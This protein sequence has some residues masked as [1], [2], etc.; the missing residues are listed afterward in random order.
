MKKTILAILLAIIFVFT[1]CNDAD[2]NSVTPAKDVKPEE[3]IT[4]LPE[5]TSQKEQLGFITNGDDIH[6]TMD[7]AT[8]GDTEVN[9][10]LY[11]DETVG[12]GEFFLENLV[13]NG[14]IYVNGGGENSGYFINVSGKNLI[15]QSKTNPKVVLDME[16]SMDGVQIASDCKV[17]VEG[18]K[19]K[20][21]TVNSS[22][23]ESA[24]NA[25][26]KG[27]LPKVSIESTA[28]VTIDGNVSLMTVLKKAKL[29][30]IDMVNDSQMYF[31]SCN[32]ESVSVHG[33]TI[34]EAWINAEYCS[35]PEDVDKIGSETGVADV[36]IGDVQYTLPKRT[37]MQENV[38]ENNENNNENRNQNSENQED[39][40]QSGFAL[41][42]YPT[43]QASG[44]TVNVAI[45]SYTAGT[46]HVLVESPD[47]GGKETTSANVKNGISAGA[48][49][50]D[51]TVIYESF[52]IS[53]PLAE[54][55]HTIN[56]ASYLDMGG[57]G[58]APQSGGMG[59]SGYVLIVIEDNEG[60]LSQVY[61]IKV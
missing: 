54:Y 32:G 3:S 19:I 12:D 46:A 4:E 33:G 24:I 36:K 40:N 28:N 7:G 6:I 26:I 16:T 29:T 51:Y 38:E 1:S 49:S 55:S 61:R 17:H 35:L 60:N 44:M 25:L 37:T 52:S 27:D 59:F 9:G 22:D 43:A 21:V 13:V 34:I 41:S 31:Y 8:L 30:S 18:D 45:S 15:I 39:E 14:T 57:N 47:V 2:K 23:T 53:S 20:S 10:D 48:G 50:D 58:E 11:I 42:G 56:I 5:E